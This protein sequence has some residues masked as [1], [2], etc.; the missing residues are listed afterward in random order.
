[1]LFTFDIA[2]VWTLKVARLRVLA[3]G[4]LH[5]IVIIR[6]FE[7]LI[8]HEVFTTRVLARVDEVM[9]GD[10]VM[11]EILSAAMVALI[12]G[13]RLFR[14]EK[15]LAQLCGAS[16]RNGKPCCRKKLSGRA[17]CRNHGGLSTGP[18]SAA[19]RAA[20]AESNRR[21]AGRRMMTP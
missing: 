9:H 3:G 7:N 5:I 14:E 2:S 18:K 1:M 21:R 19:G 12:E 15:R 6:A 17:R 20:I 13:A 16:T 11:H 10:E 4:F 8:L